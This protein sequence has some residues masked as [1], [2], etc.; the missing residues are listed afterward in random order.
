MVFSITYTTVAAWFLIHERF[1][2]GAEQSAGPAEC[3]LCSAG[4]HLW[5]QRQ[6][7]NNGG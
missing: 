1:Q 2:S 5:A 7:L 3:T 6:Q 4:V